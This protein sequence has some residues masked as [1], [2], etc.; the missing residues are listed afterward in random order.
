MCRFLLNTKHYDTT[1]PL[2]FLTRK[3]VMEKFN[4]CRR[5]F[6]WLFSVLISAYF[7]TSVLFAVI[8][9]EKN[10]HDAFLNN[11]NPLVILLVLSVGLAIFWYI[12]TKIYDNYLG[13]KLRQRGWNESS[14][15]SGL[16]FFLMTMLVLYVL[17]VLGFA[18][19]YNIFWS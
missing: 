1:M 18:L 15:L 12:G 14:Y 3:G 11:Q 4:Y 19:V 6:C 8:G 7:L 13:P 5:Y 16:G 10:V 17:P 2:R 9:P